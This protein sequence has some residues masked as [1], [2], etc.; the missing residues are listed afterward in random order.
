MD[1]VKIGGDAL[2]VVKVV[3]IG[4]FKIVQDSPSGMTWI[5][6]KSAGVEAGLSKKSMER[7]EQIIKWFFDEK[8]T[9]I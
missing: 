6:S 5:F 2:K 9:S 3:E 4:D 1:V 8:T 7:L